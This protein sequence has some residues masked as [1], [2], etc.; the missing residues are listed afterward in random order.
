MYTR[1]TAYTLL[2][3]IVCVATVLVLGQHGKAGRTFAAG[4][5][6]I[7]VARP[8]EAYAVWMGK[9]VRGRILV[10]FDRY[11]HIIGRAGYGGIPQ[12]ADANLIEYCVFENIIRKIYFIVPDQNWG[13][14]LKN[15]WTH[16]LRS[17]H[18]IERGLFL[19]S[20]TGVPIIA[21]TPSLLPHIGEQPLVYI[22][23]QVY[24]DRQARDLLEQKQ[25][26][27]DIIITV[28]DG[29]A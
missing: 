2:S 20:R 10:L 25:I 23:T 29:G 22:N 8:A 1:T 18:G 14:F 17:I 21:T 13:D 15:E 28:R 11:P 27:S 16:P 9:G 12:L 6:S 19:G 4:R 7:V 3:F 5:S 26:I 24:D